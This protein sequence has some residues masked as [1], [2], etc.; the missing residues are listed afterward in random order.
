MMD[1]IQPANQNVSFVSLTQN[2]KR[3]YA[4][5]QLA[6]TL[7]ALEQDGVPSS[8]LAELLFEYLL[9]EMEPDAPIDVERAFTWYAQLNRFRDRLQS[10]IDDIHH[11]YE[12]VHE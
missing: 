7:L 4:N 8:M 10:H 3:Q 11:V 5:D 12:D 9:I 2:P 1:D 6:K